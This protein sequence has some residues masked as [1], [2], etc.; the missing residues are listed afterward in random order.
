LPSFRISAVRYIG[1]ALSVNIPFEQQYPGR[2][3]KV[4][5][6]FYY[7]GLFYSLSGTEY[8]ETADRSPANLSVIFETPE[9]LKVF[10][11]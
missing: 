11:R 8:T 6:G 4:V 10:G 7:P 9:Q 2:P 5:S 1:F 3:Y